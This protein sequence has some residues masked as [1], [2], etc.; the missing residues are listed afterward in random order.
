MISK[1]K[2]SVLKAL[3]QFMTEE[4]FAAQPQLLEQW[5]QVETQKRVGSTLGLKQREVVQGPQRNISAYLFFCE[6]IRKEILDAN[7]GIKPNKVMIIF[8]EKWRSLSEDEKKPFIEK[9]ASDRERYNVFLESKLR[10]KKNAKPSTYNLFCTDERRVIK[11]EFPD[12]N[13]SDVRKELGRRWKNI[14]QTNPEL[15]KEKYGFVTE[16]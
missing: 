8:G 16:D 1:S 4:F 12:M 3:N 13:A 2:L 5:M 15:L 9:A 14:K 7:P 11:T 6:S 10:P